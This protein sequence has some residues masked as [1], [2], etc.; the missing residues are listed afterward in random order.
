MRKIII[1][2]IIVALMVLAYIYGMTDVF[3]S[4]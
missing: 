2:L 3:T 4:T 1:V